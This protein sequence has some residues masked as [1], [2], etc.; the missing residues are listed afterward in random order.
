[1]VSGRGWGQ[2]PAGSAAPGAA[3][4][5]TLCVYYLCIVARVWKHCLELDGRATARSI[6]KLVACS[7]HVS[8]VLILIAGAAGDMAEAASIV[9]FFACHS[10]SS[11]S[12]SEAKVYRTAEMVTVKP[13]T[14]VTCVIVLK[15]LY[16]VTRC[17]IIVQYEKLLLYHG[18][19]YLVPGKNSYLV[20]RSEIWIC[21]LF[22]ESQSR[23]GPRDSRRGLHRWRAAAAMDRSKPNERNILEHPPTS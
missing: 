17:T 5:C 18:T 1:M 20:V 21:P 7:I 11:S 19:W 16:L 2:G 14:C 23:A 9:T 12:S 15:F 22:W 8:I 13:V 10:I 6:P 4:A 3:G